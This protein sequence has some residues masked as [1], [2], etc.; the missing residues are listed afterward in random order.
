MEGVTG[1]ETDIPIAP[2]VT[3]T[4]EGHVALDVN[5]TVTTSPFASEVVV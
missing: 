5:I 4:G 2:D 1:D 3:V